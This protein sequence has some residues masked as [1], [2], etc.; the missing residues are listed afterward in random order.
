MENW[1]GTQRSKQIIID[2]LTA[3]DKTVSRRKYKDL[4]EKCVEAISKQFG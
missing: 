4:K 2:A 3:I 1:P